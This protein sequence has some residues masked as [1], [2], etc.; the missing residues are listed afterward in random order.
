MKNEKEIPEVAYEQ[1]MI[2]V[3]VSKKG[4]RTTGAHW[5]TEAGQNTRFFNYV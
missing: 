4:R 5:E 1:D 3:K 2:R